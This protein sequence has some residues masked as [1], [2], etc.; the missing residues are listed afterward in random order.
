MCHFWTFTLN[1]TDAMSHMLHNPWAY[2]CISVVASF[3]EEN[4]NKRMEVVLLWCKHEM[5]NDVA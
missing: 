2:G 3:S 5:E 4:I 1:K